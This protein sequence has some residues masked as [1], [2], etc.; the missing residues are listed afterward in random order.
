MYIYSKHTVKSGGNSGGKSM[1]ASSVI[2]NE[3]ITMFIQS[4]VLLNA[5]K[6]MFYSVLMDELTNISELNY[7][8]CVYGMLTKKHLKSDKIFIRLTLCIML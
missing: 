4:K 6:S 5:R 2:Q 7:Y 1:Y 8:L 3:F